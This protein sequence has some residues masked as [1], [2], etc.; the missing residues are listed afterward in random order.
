[1]AE[2]DP[3]YSVLTETRKLR[4]QDWTGRDLQEDFSYQY[5]IDALS[6]T[7]VVLETSDTIDAVVAPISDDQFLDMVQEYTF[8]YFYEYGHPT[9]GMA[10]ERLGSD[11]I[12]TT[13][14][15]GFGI[16]ALIVGVHRGYITREEGVNRLLKIVSFLQFAD[17][18]HGVFPHWMNGKTGDV[19]PFST[20]D[21]GGDLVETA[22]LMEGLLCARQ[23][24]NQNLI[25]E[26]TLRDVITSLWE[27]VEWDHYSRNDS[28]VLYWH[29]SPNYGW[30]M[31]FPLRGYNEALIV[32]LL[33]L[34]SPTH[35]VDADYY[36]SGWAGAGYVNGNTWYGYKLFVG[37]HFGGPLFFAHYSFMGFDPRNIKDAYANYFDQN[38][39]HTLINRSWCIDNPFNYEGY[40]E[41]CW[42]LTASDDPFGYLAHAP[43]PGTDNG[44]ITPAAAIP[45]IPY[46]PQESLGALKH[47]YRE[48]GPDLWGEYGFYDAFNLKQD[49][50]ADSY[51]A[52]DQGPIIN[53]I[54]NHRSGLLWSNF[55]AN[56]EISPA[57][58][59]A[60]FV[61]D[62]VST[63]DEPLIASDWQVYPTLGNG[64]FYLELNQIS[65]HRMPTIAISD[66]LGRKVAFESQVK[67]DQLIHI[68]LAD[69][70]IT[71]GWF[72][73]TLYDQNH[74]MGSHPV[75]VR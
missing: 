8:R 22:F 42:G 61:E 75:L 28:G 4:L 70:S 9:S 53:M 40:S 30:Q 72:W 3:G 71:S 47:F 6:V 55:M 16:M 11:D 34:A 14:G 29:W 62:P 27:D 20:F 46:T 31:N 26:N 57:L 1:K 64:E 50:F 35:P 68:K 38:R 12:V 15:T 56:P 54:E 25:A 48:H 13:G 69:N 10:R 66:L 24:F 74:N 41:N 60:G 32:Y 39:N 19:I 52:I 36:H 63:K 43:G 59:A 45:S 33:A 23:Y 7:G 17:R 2:D 44:T 73:V 58:T 18:F 65:T 21:N 5:Y 67:G 49:W 51:L 37:P